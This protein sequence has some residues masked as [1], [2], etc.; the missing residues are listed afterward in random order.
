MTNTKM[1]KAEKFAM[2]RAIPAVAA[3]PM[4]VEFIDHEIELLSNRSSTNRKLTPQQEANLKI[5]ETVTSMMAPGKR[6]TVT[7]LCKML[8][9][10]F[11]EVSNQRMTSLVTQLVKE[12]AVEKIVEK[13]RAYF[14]IVVGD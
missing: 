8:P 5:K 12:K 10:H 2:L 1:T 13:G 9:E 6:Y 7:D 3:D 14:E 11:G 4:L